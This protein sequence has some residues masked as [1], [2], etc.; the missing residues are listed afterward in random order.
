MKV[1]IAKW[2]VRKGGDGVE[3]YAT[4]EL[5]VDAVIGYAKEMA[6]LGS[7][8]EKEEAG[9]KHLAATGLLEFESEE[10]FYIV[11]EHN[12]QTALG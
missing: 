4:Q 12:L 3:V 6:L 10:C 8:G 2:D 7:D 1:W 5:A 11:E 9:R